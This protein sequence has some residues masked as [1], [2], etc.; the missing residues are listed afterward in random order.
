MA[1]WYLGGNWNGL[2]YN[3]AIK[4]ILA[5]FCLA[6]NERIDLLGAE[7]A[8]FHTN[9]GY[10]S[11]PT[12][13]DFVGLPFTELGV[14]QSSIFSGIEDAITASASRGGWRDPN[15]RDHA[16]T[17]YADTGYRMTGIASLP[18]QGKRTSWA[19]L[20]WI[21]DIINGL[22]MLNMKNW[23]AVDQT[24][25]RT[26][27]YSGGE[28]PGRSSDGAWDDMKAD[29]GTPMSGNPSRMYSLL[30]QMGSPATTWWEWK[31]DEDAV[32]RFELP[33]FPAGGTIPYSSIQMLVRGLRGGSD[34][35]APVDYEDI[36]H[37]FKLYNS[38]GQYL[39]SVQGEFYPPWGP[40]PT[41]DVF[42][43][44]VDMN[45]IKVD[46]HIDL[47]VDPDISMGYAPFYP[48]ANLAPW[49][50]P[51]EDAMLLRAW[52]ERHDIT[53]DYRSEFTYY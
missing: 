4:N 28:D 29:E 41:K 23:T 34:H 14:A 51:A 31:T 11:Y 13:A 53:F 6:I 45:L 21:R 22:Y 52:P 48:V 36:S 43:E 12:P 35:S 2:K 30:T 15:D 8:T 19:A 16:F 9:A 25:S 24:I 39:A 50:W 7:P 38:N 42:Y 49:T 17:S 1:G 26:E 3:P 37:D 33:G 10:L 18:G 47:R 32:Y 5:D 20:E 44:L 40:S 27:R 46:Q